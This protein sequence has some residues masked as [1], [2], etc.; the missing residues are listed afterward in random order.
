MNTTPPLTIGNIY[1]PPNQQTNQQFIEEFSS[2]LHE[3][4]KDCII[5][6]DFNINLLKINSE[7]TPQ[8]FYE[9]ITTE[10]FAPLITHPTRFCSSTATLIDNIFCKT[11]NPQLIHASGILTNKISDHQ[12]CFTLIHPSQKY[13]TNKYITINHR[14]PN[15]IELIK[16][17]LQQVNLS[18]QMVTNPDTDPN[19]NYNILI[20]TLTTI[21]KTHTRAKIVKFN[22][23]KHPKSPWIT[24]EI[25]RSIKFRDRLHYQWK[26]EP[27]NSQQKEALK[28]NINTYTK[29]IK[30]SI[31]SAKAEYYSRTF[32]Q[33]RDD[34][35]NTWKSI[36]QILNRNKSQDKLIE[37]L[38][39]SENKITQPE[40]ISNALNDY[41]TKIGE[42]LAA[43][44]NSNDTSYQQYLVQ[45]HPPTF[46]FQPVTNITIE[47]IILSLRSKSSSASD[48]LSTTILKSL[49][50]ELC[51]PLT[52][53]ANQIINTSIFPDRLKSAKVIP[54]FKKNDPHECNNYRPISILP[55]ISKVYE[56]LLL[57]QLNHHFESNNLHYNSQYGFRKNRST[58]HA[59]LELTDTI[60][61]QMDN[62]K[63]PLSIFLDLS[64]AFDTLNH[65]ILLNKLKHYGLTEKSLLLCKSY[66]TN[67]QQYVQYITPSRPRIITTGV[68]QGS[69]LGPFLFL[70]YVNDFHKCCNNFSMIHY[71]DDTTLTTT[72]NTSQTAENDINN[73]LNS[74]YTW[75]NAN[76]LVLNISK[77]K[78][79]IFHTPQRSITPPQLH[80]N[81]IPIV[82]VQEFDFLGITLNQH[83]TWKNHIKKVS[84]KIAKTSGILNKIKNYMPKYI[85]LQLYHSLILPHLNYGI[86][87]WGHNTNSLLLLQKRIIR[88]IT[89]SKYNAHTDPLFRQLNLLKIHDIRTIFELKFYHKLCN[90]K[91]PEYFLQ[92]YIQTNQDIH[93][94][95][96][97]NRHS[98]VIPTHHHQF[99]Q[100]SLKY[101]LTHTV[102]NTLDTILNLV[103]T[104]SLE[105]LSLRL[106]NTLISQYSPTCN[107]PNCR[108]C[109]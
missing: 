105:A 35:K 94:I 65:P 19:Y 58:E 73:Q 100:T 97:R 90:N 55:A 68:P 18:S 108:I 88:T 103:H 104:H 106:K 12:P 69:I 62:N 61:T 9:A 99:F 56:K 31:R 26:K 53:I 43:Q 57:Q 86:L 33:F 7:N 71:A 72:I 49:V 91:L 40:N 95:N 76:K 92:S 10:G 44:I 8:N 59:T 67:R 22:K 29:I 36:N 16:H 34:P 70:I 47:K 109:P 96:T 3:L 25:I 48:E 77:T 93:N 1:K 52:I 28:I 74:V 107:I 80:I 87:V 5:T 15:F 50:H 20:N 78:Y 51:Q 54:I 21:M 60:L 38:N 101:T 13:E 24:N 2:F 42:N 27:P 17:D 89:N 14:P 82:R 81:N 66:L 83:M 39:I 85:L 37:Y 84:T 63:T 11:T 46:N 23:H 30:K 4:N 6:G 41:F 64:K 102:N 98:L 75:L 79:I 45:A 32:H